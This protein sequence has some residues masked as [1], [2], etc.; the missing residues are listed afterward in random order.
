M[1]S[2]EATDEV[3][4]QAAQPQSAL[5]EVHEGLDVAV[6][7]PVAP[8]LA[9]VL[10]RCRKQGLDVYNALGKDDLVQSVL[11]RDQAIEMLRAELGTAWATV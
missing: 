8:T 3:M 6:A 10:A 7:G 11:L 9:Q 5:A 4:A 1:A 2:S